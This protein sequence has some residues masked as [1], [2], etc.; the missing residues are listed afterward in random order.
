MRFF[1]FFILSFVLHRAVI[2]GE[3]ISL[4]FETVCND[5]GKFLGR[6]S[7][8]YV[9]LRICVLRGWPW[10]QRTWR[11]FPFSIANSNCV[12]FSMIFRYITSPVRQS[13]LISRISQPHLRGV[14]WPWSSRR[15]D[16]AW[17]TPS[18]SIRRCTYAKEMENGIYLRAVVNA[19]PV[20]KRIRKNKLVT[21]RNTLI[22]PPLT[23]PSYW[24]WAK[25]DDRIE[26]IGYQRRMRRALGARSFQYATIRLF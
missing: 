3:E 24:F 1:L 12:I 9:R 14:R 22:S 16:D 4:D 17:I 21:V 19:K 18:K 25:C 20:S 2:F 26:Q 6:L 8:D 15:L 10:D 11:I 7:K 23:P 5:V 13:R